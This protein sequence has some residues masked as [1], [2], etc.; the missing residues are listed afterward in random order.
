MSSAPINRLRRLTKRKL[1]GMSQHDR[2]AFN[3][4]LDQKIKSSKHSRLSD[5]P[6]SQIMPRAALISAD[7]PQLFVVIDTCTLVTYRAEFVNFVTRQKQMFSKQLS[8]IRFVISC[9]VL[10]ELDKCNRPAKRKQATQMQSKTQAQPKRSP[11]AVKKSNSDPNLSD[12]PLPLPSSS[13]GVRIDE[14]PRMFM[15]FIEEEMRDG[16]VII[17]ELDPFKQLKLPPGEQNFEIIN[18]DDRILECCMRSKNFIKSRPHHSETSVILVT[19]DNM[20]KSKATTFYITSYRWR[21]FESKY[22]NFGLDHY[23]ATPEPSIAAC[24]A[25]SSVAKPKYWAADGAQ[26]EN[27]QLPSP[28]MRKD[29]LRRII[30]SRISLAPRKFE[31]L[32]LGERPDTDDD[33]VIIVEEIIKIRE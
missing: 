14:P 5:L 29:D 26:D 8:P 20:F 21:E 15:R 23:I 27:T 3:E 22:K 6:S 7:R 25:T 11:S 17:A 1:T 9:V 2:D 31:K 30:E 32:F 4:W 16:D 18:K 13:T 10:E 28:T 12:L 19:E 33:S 24:M